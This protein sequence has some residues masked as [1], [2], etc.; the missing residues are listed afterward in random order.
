MSANSCKEDP[1]KCPRPII[2]AAAGGASRAGFFTASIIGYL[3]DTAKEKD[4]RLDASEVTKRLFAISGVSGGSVGAAIDRRGDRAHKNG[5]QPCVER[6]PSL[7]YGDK[8]GNWRDC[9]E[10]LTA[11]DFLTPVSIG[12]VFRDIVRFGW[13][14][15][16]A[17]ALGKIVGRTFLPI[18]GHGYQ[19]NGRTNARAICAAR[20]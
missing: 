2:I 20:S 13:W 15:D 16:R 17:T 8:I 9:L 12:L 18:G 14:E 4:P 6:R 3:L 11:G 7:W 5:E 19:T 10:A 1:A